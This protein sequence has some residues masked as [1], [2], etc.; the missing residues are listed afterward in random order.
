MMDLF[1]SAAQER[2]KALE[3]VVQ[4][5][6]SWMEKAIEAVRLYPEKYATGEQLRIYLEEKI[7]HPHHYNVY[8]ALIMA[9]ARQGILRKTGEYRPCQRKESHARVNPVY[10]LIPQLS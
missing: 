3:R 2:D 5:S 10:Q 6:Y 7:G 8:G 4:G 9:C 1:S